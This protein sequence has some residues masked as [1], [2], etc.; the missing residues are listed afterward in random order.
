MR[1]LIL[2]HRVPFPQNGGY[3]IVVGNTI[4]GLINHGH[5][6]SLISLN[7]KKHTDKI[8]EPD[9]LLRK[10]TYTEY[11]IDTRISWIEFVSN[12]FTKNSYNIDKYYDAGFEK[13]LVQNLKDNEYD[14]I[15]LEGLF[16]VPYLA[17]IRKSSKTRIVYRAHNIEH[18]V[19]RRLAQ[20]KGDPIK[21][22]YL[23]L[24]ARRVKTYELELLNKFDGIAVFT[25][26]DKTSMLS[27][28]TKI[29]MRVLPIGVDLAMYSPAPEKTE[30]PSLF[31]LGSLDWLPNREGIEWFMNNFHKDI[32]DGELK[33]KFYVAGNNI[34]EEFDEYE[35]PG[36]VFIQGEVDD[37]LEFINSKS[38]MIV[39]L[40][41]GGGMRVKIVEGMA[42]Q[43]CII[44][45]TIGAE[46]INFMH[47]ES[48]LIAN[49]AD[50][51]YN[52]VL[53][54]VLDE[55]YCRTIGQNARKLMEEQHDI[56]KVTESL[57]DFYRSI[58]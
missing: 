42:M 18:Q 19:W 41:S 21:K 14:I 24:L 32:V 36:K 37:A 52:A 15:Q 47:G 48:I 55:E 23:N 13:L 20:Q 31:F 4:K 22:W 3:P 1:I 53:K 10:I 39:P 49:N 17:A 44:S 26:Q 43:K 33:V 9:E 11:D 40:L 5:E 45:T 58:I 57:V 35:V 28:G 51:F 8:L 50:E 46:G 38:I 27:F 2:T 7:V 54:C 30:C 56:N 34:P 29:P 6:V 12:I 25:G 16:V